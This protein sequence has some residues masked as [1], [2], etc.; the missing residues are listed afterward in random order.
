ML[1]F[2]KIMRWYLYVTFCHR[3]NGHKLGPPTNGQIA[4][5]HDE[6]KLLMFPKKM[7]NSWGVFK[8][9]YP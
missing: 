4:V 5:K 6:T 7:K 2:P 9:V 3:V 1:C 8:K